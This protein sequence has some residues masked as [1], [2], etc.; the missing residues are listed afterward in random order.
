MA[1][2]PPPPPKILYEEVLNPIERPALTITNVV[3]TANPDGT[4][5]TVS[6]TLVNHGSGSTQ[7]V[8]VRVAAL[9][10][11]GVELFS[12]GAVPSTERIAPDST[13]TFAVTLEKRPGVNQYHVEAIAR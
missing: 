8:S 9:N 6:G 3:E 2:P 5:V 4:T 7:Q 11:D 1:P 12:A 10:A 13:A